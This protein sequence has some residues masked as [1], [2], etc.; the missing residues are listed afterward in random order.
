MGGGE[1]A[2][3][4][5]GLLISNAACLALFYY[6]YR[7][8]EMETDARLA[9]RSLVYLALFPTAFF[10]LAAYAE[11]LLLLCAVGGA[12]SRAARAVDPGRAVG[13]FGA[14]GAPARQRR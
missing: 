14:A 7:L 8:V 6:F 9:R 3:L 12:L 10:L 5:A 2:Y 4:L 11:S 13:L 1:T